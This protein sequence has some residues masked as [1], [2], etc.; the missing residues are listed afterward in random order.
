MWWVVLTKPSEHQKQQKHRPARPRVSE[1][2][3]EFK[4][5]DEESTVGRF[6]QAFVKVVLLA[7]SIGKYD[8]HDKLE[9]CIGRAI[10]EDVPSLERKCSRFVQQGRKRFRFRYNMFGLLRSIAIFGEIF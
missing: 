10:D 3:L 2:S 7:K 5:T 6:I 1:L 9:T 4:L 8:Q